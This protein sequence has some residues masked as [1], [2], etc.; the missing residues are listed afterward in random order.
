M[1]GAYRKIIMK[2]IDLKWNLMKYNDD[3]DNLIQS[4]MGAIHKENIPESDSNGKFV[5]LILEFSL[6]SST[7]ATM[8]LREVLKCD[9]SVASQVSL[10]EIASQ[11][12]SHDGNEE[13]ASK[14]PKLENEIE[15]KN[16]ITNVHM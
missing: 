10:H 16:E 6:P 5:A 14:V 4:D 11:K 8:A 15:N 13:V 7:Y 2:P 9:T 3:T 1:P 12:R